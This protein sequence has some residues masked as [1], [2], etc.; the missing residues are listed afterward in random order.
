[1]LNKRGTSFS[2]AFFESVFKRVLFPA[3]TMCG[4]QGTAP[5][6]IHCLQQC[7]DLGSL[8]GLLLDCATRP[9]SGGLSVLEFV[10]CGSPSPLP[11]PSSG[12]LKHCTI[13][14]RFVKRAM[15]DFPAQTQPS[16]VPLVVIRPFGTCWAWLF[17]VHLGCVRMQVPCCVVIPSTC[18]VEVRACRFS[19]T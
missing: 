19:L 4:M 6:C 16:R 17:G 7:F 14:S 9:L 5:T 15:G 1:M 2:A 10:C 11:S 18:V 3:S 12:T 8:L 13:A